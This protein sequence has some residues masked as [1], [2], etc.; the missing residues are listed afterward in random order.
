MVMEA[1]EEMTLGPG[2]SVWLALE[3][4]CIY[5]LRHQNMFSAVLYSTLELPCKKDFKKN[6]CCYFADQNVLRRDLGSSYVSN[7]YDRATSSK[8]AKRVWQHQ[9]VMVLHLM[10]FIFVAQ[11]DGSYSATYRTSLLLPFMFWDFEEMFHCV[12]SFRRRS[13]P[14]ARWRVGNCRAPSR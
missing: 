2:R 11:G 3:P 9:Q 14:W 5:T 6:Y 8:T 12:K 7:V 10:Y 1:H 13:Q 4:G